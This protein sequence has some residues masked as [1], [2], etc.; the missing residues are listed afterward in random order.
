MDILLFQHHSPSLLCAVCGD[1]ASW[2]HYGVRTCEGCKGFFKRTVQ[3]NKKYFCMADKNCPMD[4]R[5]RNHCKFCRFQK[6]LA[7]GM[8]KEV[9]RRDALKGRR[10]RLPSK[11]RSRRRLRETNSRLMENKGADIMHVYNLPKLDEV[12]EVVPYLK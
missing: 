2:Q 3:T 9:V 6:C 5:S 4:K 1:N 8:V 7:V 12:Y 11:S 10:G